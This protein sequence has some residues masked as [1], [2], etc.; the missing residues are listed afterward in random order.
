MLIA[1]VALKGLEIHQTDVKTTCLDS[2]LDEEIYYCK[3]QYIYIYICLYNEIFL[4][5]N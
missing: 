5:R 4:F 2:E 3:K 1:I